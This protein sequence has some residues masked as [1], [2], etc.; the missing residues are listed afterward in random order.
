MRERS[1]EELML[2]WAGGSMAAF[3]TLYG[4]YRGPLYRYV[5]RLCGD[6]TTANDLYQG[7]WEKVINARRTWRPR[8]PFR[9]WL[10]RVARNHVMDH[11]RRV[12]PATGLDTGALASSEPGP[13]AGVERSERE[14]ALKAALRSLP[15]EQRDA[16]LLK[17]EGGLGLDDIARVTGAG[18]ETAKSRLRYAVARMKQALLEP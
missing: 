7:A 9:A 11:F 17:L 15:P 2:D 14:R 8:A 4:R 12:A 16:L 10:F 6:E 1:D 5:L 3:D 13:D 18:R